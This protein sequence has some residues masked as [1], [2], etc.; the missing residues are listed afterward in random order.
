MKLIM[1]GQLQL[2]KKSH[3]VIPLILIDKQ[4]VTARLLEESGIEFNDE[5]V[6]EFGQAIIIIETID[7]K[8]RSLIGGDNDG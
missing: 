3:N 5:G 4:S 6:A 7:S 2:I 8:V 1:T